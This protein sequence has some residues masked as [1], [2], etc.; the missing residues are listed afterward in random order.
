MLTNQHK[1]QKIVLN[2]YRQDGD[3]LFSHIVR[4]DETWIS[5]SN[6]VSQQQSM[7]WCYSYSPTSKKFRF[8]L[9]SKRKLM[10]TVFWDGKSVTPIDFM[11][12]HFIQLLFDYIHS[13]VYQEEDS[14][15]LGKHF[16]T[17]LHLVLTTHLETTF[18]MWIWTVDWGTIVWKQ[19]RNSRLPLSTCLI[20]S[21]LLLC[22][23]LKKLFYRY[24]MS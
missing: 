11:E 6:A 4:G 13:Y 18:S 19:R 22:G 1:M 2:R 15:I 10:V 7:Q 16:S 3:D 21:G 12:D 23:V 5:Y 14:R 24:Q 8:A 9:Y 20:S 17:I